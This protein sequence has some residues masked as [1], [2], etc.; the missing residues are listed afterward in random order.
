MF[1]ISL[2]IVGKRFIRLHFFNHKFNEVVRLL[3]HRI[4]WTESHPLNLVQ[5]KRRST[6]WWKKYLRPVI[7]KWKTCKLGGNMFIAF[8]RSVDDV[9]QEINFLLCIDRN[10]KLQCQLHT[11]K[12]FSSSSLIFASE[13]K[14]INAETFEVILS[15]AFQFRC[16]TR[17]LFRTF[18]SNF[19]FPLLSQMALK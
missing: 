5:K 2:K 19:T 1:L 17:A 6:L 11:R 18:A 9:N 3:P 15:V 13:M 14:C 12:S 7:A 4:T 8:E 10:C 16:I